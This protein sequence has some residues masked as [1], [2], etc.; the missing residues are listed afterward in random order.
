MRPQRSTSVPYCP[1]VPDPRRWWVLGF[2]LLAMLIVSVDTTVLIV[3]IPTIRRE[4]DTSFTAVEWVITGYGLV[5]A[6]L[7]V[8]GGRLGDLFGTRRALVVGTAIFGVGSLVASASTDVWGLILGEGV[9]EGVGAALIAP[10]ALALIVV[11][12]TGRERATAFAAW[13]SVLTSGAVLGPV[14]GGYLTTYHSWRWAF[15]INVGL[16]PIVIVGLLALAPRD[17][18]SKERPRVDLAGAALI[19]SATF[20]VLFAVSQGTTYG[21]LEPTEPFTLGALTAWPTSA[22][23]SVVP[24]ALAVGLLLLW[25]FVR[26]ERRIESR[27]GD[28]L[29]DMAQFGVR[30]FRQGTVLTSLGG[31]AQMGTSFCIALFLQESRQLTPAQNGLWV[32]PIGVG[33]VVGAPFAGWLV[34]RINPTTIMRV[35]M[36][37]Q[38]GALLAMAVL[39]GADA[40]YAVIGATFGTYGIGS[41]FVFSQV[42]RLMLSDIAPENTGA[43]SGMSSA[44][45]QIVA[46][47]GVAVTAAVLAAAAADHGF[48][49]GIRVALL[50][51]TAVLAAG[52]VLTWR[53]APL[54]DAS[55]AS[56]AIELLDAELEAA[57]LPV[58][59]ADDRR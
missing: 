23:I 53:I 48:Q 41:G 2:A 45:R 57:G 19:A 20:F 55:R 10:N 16:V 34:G 31:F 33:S 44:S 5:F 52:S 59:V 1:A 21:Y 47:S 49:T 6:C 13:A 9:I 22:P 7:L 58:T 51:T 8:I 40:P 28:P 15:R 54:H 24:C 3:S 38:T 46:S 25:A 32:I 30:T 29:F 42:N 11:T 36:L 39:L 37:L 43:A 35:G 17:R 14:L 4:L 26:A 50:L 56:R 27:H 18:P 12:F